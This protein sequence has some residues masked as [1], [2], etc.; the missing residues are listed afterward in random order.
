MCGNTITW[1]A[2][3]AAYVD[4]IRSVL[5]KFQPNDMTKA[6]PTD[7]IGR[8]IAGLNYFLVTD[9]DNTLIGDDNS[10]L[11]DL[12]D[13]LTNYRD[14]IGFVVAT[15]RTIDSAVS[16]LQNLMCRA[17]YYHLL[18]GHGNLLRTGA[19]LQPGVGYPYLRKME[20][21][22]NRCP[23]CG[24]FFSHLSGGSHPAKIQN[25]L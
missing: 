4:N 15:G 16:Y 14:C 10:H 5:K 25:Q 12:C 3:G 7:A 6:R 23:A 8:R 20:P 18:C 21:G 22:K 2:H 19:P 9:I 17:G 11:A 24:F 13:L 1:E